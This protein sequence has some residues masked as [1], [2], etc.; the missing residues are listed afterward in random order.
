[1]FTCPGTKYVN[2]LFAK[3]GA[4]HVF[5]ACCPCP[6]KLQKINK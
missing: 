3:F 2:E 4:T 5:V 1:M 6:N